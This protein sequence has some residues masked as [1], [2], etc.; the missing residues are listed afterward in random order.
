MDEPGVSTRTSK[1]LVRIALDASITLQTALTAKAQKL[2]A[3]LKEI[4]RLLV[5]TFSQA[6]EMLLISRH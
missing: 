2:E 5:R 6:I 3:D 4:D 1:E